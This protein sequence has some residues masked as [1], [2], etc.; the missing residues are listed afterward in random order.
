MDDEEATI[1]RTRKLAERAEDRRKRADEV[2]A[3]KRW[4]QEDAE[5]WVAFRNPLGLVTPIS[6][7]LLYDDTAKQFV[8]SVP[9]N[10]PTEAFE[11]LLADRAPERSL[12]EAVAK[13]WLLKFQDPHGEVW[14]ESE[15]V[16]AVFPESG[17]NGPPLRTPSC[18]SPAEA[19][20]NNVELGGR[21]A[22][23]LAENE[24]RASERA[25]FSRAGGSE[26]PAEACANNVELGGH[27]A[28][29]LAENEPRAS[30]RAEFSRWRDKE[31]RGSA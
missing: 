29:E 30:E 19:C 25:E 8:G 1:A 6:Y 13:G 14:Y 24:P 9:E 15:Q 27:P 16:K 4:S 2:F 21:P 18:E 5:R 20:A 7:A 23:E 31:R 17:R 22:S 11:K 26:P 12:V 3:R 28:S 10:S